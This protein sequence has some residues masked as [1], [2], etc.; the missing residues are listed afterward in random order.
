MNPKVKFKIDAQKDLPTFK[1][2][3]KEAGFDD[4]RNL[5]WA[6]FKKHPQLRK[7]VKKKSDIDYLFIKKYIEGLYKKN[8]AV[9]AANFKVYETNWKKKE[10]RFFNLV[11]DLF[12]NRPWPKGKYIAYATIW[13]MFPRFL[14]D[15]TFQIPIKYK[16]KKYVNAIIAHELLHFM[17]YDYFCENYPR[18]KHSENSIY[19]WHI[20]EIFNS[21][22]QNS[23]TWLDV[24]EKETMSYP[25][26]KKIISQLKKKY[27]YPMS[28]KIKN[29]ISDIEPFIKILLRRKK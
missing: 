15:K 16:N 4:G 29:L 12:H 5:E 8:I 2:F 19:V 26:H 9:A 14:E 13:G 3:I 24:F 21:L 23:P 27:K 28:L 25:E 7:I 6:I 10:G 22:V 18:Y 1:A 17:F 20:S 11:K